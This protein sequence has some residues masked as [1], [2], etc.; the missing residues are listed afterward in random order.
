MVSIQIPPSLSCYAENRETLELPGST[1]QDLLTALRHR[2]PELG[3]HLLRQ[4]GSLRP[5]VN[6]FINDESIRGLRQ[7]QTPVA[8]TDIVT[9]VPSIAGG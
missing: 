7:L 8:E 2:F 5:Y 6:V 9:V 1:V 4:D 3:R